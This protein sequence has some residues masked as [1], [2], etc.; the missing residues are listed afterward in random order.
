MKLA[1]RTRVTVW[2]AKIGH[3]VE[4][5]TLDPGFRW[6]TGMVVHVLERTFYDHRTH[7]IQA[8]AAEIDQ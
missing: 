2:H 5:H 8:Y 4:E 6:L 1:A 7:P 3:A